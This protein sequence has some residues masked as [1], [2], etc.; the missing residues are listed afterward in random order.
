MAKATK[1]PRNSQIW[2]EAGIVEAID[3]RA[4]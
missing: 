4:C 2:V 3:C 1:K